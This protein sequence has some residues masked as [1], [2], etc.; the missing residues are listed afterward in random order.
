[1]RRH[2][3]WRIRETEEEDDE[4]NMSSK[5]EWKHRVDPF[6]NECVIALPPAD[7]YLILLFYVFAVLWAHLPSMFFT[8]HGD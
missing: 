4:E 2:N 1:M 8:T 6:R 7:N 3:K 5:V